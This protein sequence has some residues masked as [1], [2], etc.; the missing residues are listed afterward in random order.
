MFD[1]RD[2]FEPYSRRLVHNICLLGCPRETA[3]RVAKRL[4][5]HPLSPH[6]A[7][8]LL[9]AASLRVAA[10]RAALNARSEETES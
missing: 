6:D 10:Q 3:I 8:R 7:A 9:R 5:A 4:A 2:Y 1:F